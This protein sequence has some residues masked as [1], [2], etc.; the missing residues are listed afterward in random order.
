MFLFLSVGKKPPV[1]A[2]LYLESKATE[3]H[4]RISTPKISIILLIC[5]DF[6]TICSI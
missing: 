2:N 6:A 5:K 4:K 3:R 1:A